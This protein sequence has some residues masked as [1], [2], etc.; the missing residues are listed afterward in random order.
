MT[1]TPSNQDRFTQLAREHGVTP[2]VIQA[3]ASLLET[4]GIEPTADHLHSL[5]FFHGSR[6]PNQFPLDKPYL[7][8]LHVAATRLMVQSF[9]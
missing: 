1:D 9:T 6:G 2:D 5:F 3:A 8:V 7:M 4:D